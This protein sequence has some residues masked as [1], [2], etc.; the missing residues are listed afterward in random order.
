MQSERV[1]YAEGEAEWVT[2]GMRGATKQIQTHGNATASQWKR[3]R[4]G[5]KLNIHRQDRYHHMAALVRLASGAVAATWQAAEDTEGE[6]TQ[7]LRMSMSKD[8]GRSWRQSWQ[9]NITRYGGAM[10]SPVPHVDSAGRLWVVYVESEGDC[11]RRSKPKN[12]WP[13]GG[14]LK[15]CLLAARRRSPSTFIPSVPQRRLNGEW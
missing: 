5:E 2:R 3:K 4:E 7:H 12:K 6:Q 11:R 13:V 10:W 9:L 1:V 14:S 15:V 8:A